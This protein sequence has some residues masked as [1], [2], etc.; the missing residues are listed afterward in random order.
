[1]ITSIPGV[2]CATGELFLFIFI[3][4]F[5]LHLLKHCSAGWKTNFNIVIILLYHSCGNMFYVG[6]GGV[7]GM[8]CVKT[9]GT[10]TAI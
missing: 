6:A 3:F 10:S 8:T 2:S 4:L 5:V 9:G 7:E 1:M